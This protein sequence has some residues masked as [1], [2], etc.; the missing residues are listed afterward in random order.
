[1]IISW[2]TGRMLFKTISN[3]YGMW[4]NCEQLLLTFGFKEEQPLAEST[5]KN[6]IH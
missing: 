5:I 6:D 4:S 1:M 3:Y 2:P